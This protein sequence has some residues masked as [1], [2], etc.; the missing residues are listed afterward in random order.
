MARIRTIKPE[1]WTDEELSAL[2]EATHILA[3]ALLNHA[4]DFGWFNANPALVRA[5]CSPIR[6]PSVS[7]PESLRSLQTIGYIRIGTAPCG[8]RYGQVVKFSEHQRV[9]HATKSKIAVQ[10]ITWDDFGNPPENFRSPPESFRPEQGTGNREQGTGI[11][12]E[13]PIGDLSPA[14]AAPM[15]C[16]PPAEQSPPED[17]DPPGT[18]PCPVKRIIRA[19]HEVLPMLAAVRDFPEQSERMLRARWRSSADR[20]SVDWWRGFFEYVKGCPF[21]VGEKNDFQAD[22]MWLVRP[23]NFAKVINGNYE[24][25]AAA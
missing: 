20:Q 1:F 23:T 3:A 21:L 6:E 2:P 4:D 8:K 7:I 18:P 24:N 14:P 12:A 11:E 22:L 17:S 15:A 5:A 25:R 16:N 19:Y 9:S 13:S 10:S